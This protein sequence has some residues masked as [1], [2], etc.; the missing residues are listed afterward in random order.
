MKKLIKIV[1]FVAVVVAMVITNPKKAAHNEAIAAEYKEALQKKVGLL[2]LLAGQKTL[3]KV[4]DSTV[5]VSD[6]VLVSVG[7]YTSRDD[8]SSVVSVGLFN[9]VFVFSKDDIIEEMGRALGM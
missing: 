1:L 9:H 3:E 6:Y 8:M 2:S 5:E 4:V 7:R